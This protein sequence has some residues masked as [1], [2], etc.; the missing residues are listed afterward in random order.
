[1]QGGLIEVPWGTALFAWGD[2]GRSQAESAPI[3]GL[4]VFRI[5]RG[6]LF[7]I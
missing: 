3:H 5:S 4:K 2:V 1:M 7:Y 6:V